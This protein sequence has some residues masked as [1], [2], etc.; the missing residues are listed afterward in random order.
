M[1]IVGFAGDYLESRF[2]LRIH[3]LPVPHGLTLIRWIKKQSNGQQASVGIFQEIKDG[4]EKEIVLK[5]HGFRWKG[6]LYRQMRNEISV[7]EAL[8]GYVLSGQKDSRAR[9]PLLY[10]AVQEK[11]SIQITREC[12]SGTPFGELQL[13]AKE[14]QEI[15]SDSIA[16]LESITPKIDGIISRRTWWQ[17]MI[18]FPFYLLG[19][20][21]KYPSRLPV[22]IRASVFFYQNIFQNFLKKSEFVL[23]HKDLSPANILIGN[24]KI[25]ILDVELLGLCPKPAENALIAVHY[26]KRWGITD[27]ISYLRRQIEPKQREGFCALSIYYGV[28]IMAI[29]VIGHNGVD[30]REDG[31]EFLSAFLTKIVPALT[32]AIEQNV[33]FI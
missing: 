17:Y 9:L 3:T 26:L 19:A 33:T 21:G 31:F 5:R 24:D 30:E 4:K 7:L 23:T 22:L 1:L 11:N 16:V 14:E 29:G 15:I 8:R 28:Q 2:G 27:M 20:I 18:T 10:S 25:S 12:L 32:S 6:T 13:S